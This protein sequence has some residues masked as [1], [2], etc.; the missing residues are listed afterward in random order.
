MGE[1]IDLL[2]RSTFI[3]EQLQVIEIDWNLVKLNVITVGR[4][5]IEV[6]DIRLFCYI[7]GFNVFIEAIE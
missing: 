2:R 3:Y 7:I 4:Y 5:R 6:I 1:L